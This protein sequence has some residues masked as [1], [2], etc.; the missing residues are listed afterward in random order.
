[1][2]KEVET[3]EVDVSILDEGAWLMFP[4]SQEDERCIGDF[5]R[6]FQRAPDHVVFNPQTP[7]WKFAG[8]VWKSEE[9]ARR[10]QNAE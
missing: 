3:V 10:W 5:M 8:P 6:V 2:Y 1:M 4:A 7:M 9:L